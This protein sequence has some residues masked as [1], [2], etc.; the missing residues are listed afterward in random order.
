[1]SMYELHIT[2]E[3][4]PSLTQTIDFDKFCR[5]VLKCKCN[6]IELAKGKYPMQ[7]MLAMKEGKKDDVDAIAWG[8]HIAAK[9]DALMFNPVR[10]KVES[11]L[12]KGPSAYFEAHWKFLCPTEQD[13]LAQNYFFEVHPDAGILASRN[14]LHD[15]VYYMSQRSY[16]PDHNDAKKLFNETHKKIQDAMLP[17]EGVHYERVVWDSFPG[18]DE[19]W[20]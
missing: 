18:L 10:I 17:L 8:K 13:Y 12:K 16:S 4:H 20:A 9:L 11:A 15:H 2:V 6:L 3:E 5:E 19:G 1:M 7:L 14:R